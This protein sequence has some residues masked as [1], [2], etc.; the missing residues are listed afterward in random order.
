MG[1]A[2]YGKKP[3]VSPESKGEELCYI[4]ERGDWGEAVTKSQLKETGSLKYSGF[5]LAES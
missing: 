5:S 3:Q 2:S 4:E 1:H